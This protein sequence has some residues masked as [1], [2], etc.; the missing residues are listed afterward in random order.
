MQFHVFPAEN[1]AAA[2][3]CLS[4][5]TAAEFAAILPNSL[6]R[7]EGAPWSS[8]PQNPRQQA[9]KAESMFTFSQHYRNFCSDERGAMAIEY[10]LIAGAMFLAL[11][12]AIYYVADAVSDK[13][14]LIPDWLNSI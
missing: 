4:D 3:A 2:A 5:R 10:S 1:R 8:L 12:P 7:R 6:T 11:V 9:V 13:F 14:L